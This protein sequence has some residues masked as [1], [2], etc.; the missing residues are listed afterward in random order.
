MRGKTALNTPQKAK[1]SHLPRLYHCTQLS[2]LAELRSLSD[3]PSRARIAVRQPA[4]GE[5]SDASRHSIR[6]EVVAKLKLD[7]PSKH[8]SR[9]PNLKR[10]QDSELFSAKLQKGHND[11]CPW[12]GNV[13]DENLASY[14]PLPRAQVVSGYEARLANFQDLSHLPQLSATAIKGMA[15]LHT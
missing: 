14:P 5:T 3:V 9:H 13:C 6:L 12:L 4:E 2:L 10:A 15:A 11:G 1:L 7:V 8:L